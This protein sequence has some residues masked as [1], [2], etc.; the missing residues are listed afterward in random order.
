MSLALARENTVQINVNPGGVASWAELACG[1]ENIGNSM[2]EVLNQGYYLCD[3]GFGHTDVT[4][5]QVTL[6][7]SGKRKKGDTAQDYIFA[8]AIRYGFG[9]ARETQARLTYSDGTIIEWSC[10]LVNI[11][12]S[13]GD[14]GA[15]E[16]VSVELHFNGVPNI[17]SG[18]LLGEITVVSLAGTNNGDTK[19]YVNP[20]LTALH[21]YKYKVVTALTALPS[22]DDV[23]ITGWTAWNGVADVTAATGTYI[24]V[25]EVLTADNKIKKLGTQVVTAKA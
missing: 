16:N 19:L 1:F 25:A 3:A 12:A 20:A 22:F 11:Q 24:M 17:I 4:G 23:L 14:A 15:S 5:G 13:S 2:S 7:L 10:T 18:G 6:S 21:S 9:S 8:P